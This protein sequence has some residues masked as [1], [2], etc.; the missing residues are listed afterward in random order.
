[1][2]RDKRIDAYID[3]APA[4]ARPI[5]ARVR[6]S[7]HE[8][9]PEAIET[10]KWSHPSFDYKGILC[11]MA[12]FKQYCALAFWKH[13]LVIGKDPKTR[14][15]LDRL[16]R[17]Q[18][19]ADVPSKSVLARCVKTAMALNEDGVK[20]V[21]PKS[22]PKKPIPMHAALKSALARNKKAAAAFEAF[23]PSHRREYLE[24]IADAKQ[25]DTRARRVAQAVEW[26]AEG[27]PRNWKYAKR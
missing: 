20:I 25:D 26:M 12:A 19:L 24:W 11:G 8:H 6:E 10:L 21:R 5:L 22:A 3:R 13:D 23:S 15:A 27:K 18:K 14:E 17:M 16:G 1:M 4:F 2:S 9:C 7:V